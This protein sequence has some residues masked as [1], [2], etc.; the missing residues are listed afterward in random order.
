MSEY[1]F[2]GGRSDGRDRSRSPGRAVPRFQ[3]P[4]MDRLANRRG[5]RTEER[6]AAAWIASEDEFVLN[7]RKQGAVIRVRDGRAKPIDYLVAVLMPLDT[8]KQVQDDDEKEFDIRDPVELISS[9][10]QEQKSLATLSEDA[11]GY[12]SLDKNHRDFWQMIVD[13]TNYTIAQFDD[14]DDP[15]NRLV[16]TV[17]PDIDNVLRG[18]SYDELVTLE[19]KVNTMLNSGSP[20]VDTDFWS[21]MLKELL[22]RKAKARLSQLY[23]Q[24]LQK[25]VDDLKAEQRLLAQRTALELERK[26]TKSE[27]SKNLKIDYDPSMESGE[28]GSET[29]ESVSY[30][31]FM[32]QLQSRRS[33]IV[34]KRFVPKAPQ[35]LNAEPFVDEPPQP[36]KVQDPVEL[37]FLRES[38]IPLRENEEPFTNEE[39]QYSSSS[40]IKPKYLARVVN[41]IEWNKHNGNPDEPPPK[42]VNGYR[43][44]IYY[45]Q[46]INSKKA[47]TY[48]IVREGGKRRWYGNDECII[49]FKAPD[50]YQDIAFRI[51][52]RQ[53]DQSAHENAGFYSKFEN[54]VLRLNFK[55]KRMVYRK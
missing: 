8:H 11:Q 16:N 17:A 49:V 28:M 6:Q 10:A 23:E 52:D 33:E 26:M 19:Q 34:T 38:E 40:G 2:R 1:R 21:R 14:Q 35:R 50:Y 4:H 29:K 9:L 55:F 42:A 46:L 15:E 41:I 36:E 5:A 39:P 25:R 3:T 45:P 43:F 48:K 53:W 20:A 18:K 51:L 44:N 37:L 47:P 27:D 7:Q 24:S 30:D 22:A 31:E 54:G 13:L 12:L 32:E